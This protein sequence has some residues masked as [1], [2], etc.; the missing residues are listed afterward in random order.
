MLNNLCTFHTLYNVL[1]HSFRLCGTSDIY[2]S[3]YSHLTSK[4][5]T[6][7]SP[8]HSNPSITTTHIIPPLLN[9]CTEMSPMQTTGYNKYGNSTS[10]I[11]LTTWLMSYMQMILTE[12]SYNLAKII[13]ISLFLSIFWSDLIDYIKLCKSIKLYLC[14][15]QTIIRKIPQNLAKF[16]T[17]HYFIFWSGIVS[18]LIIYKYSVSSSCTRKGRNYNLYVSKY[19]QTCSPCITKLA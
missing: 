3:L 5:I 14:C 13:N 11:I 16:W 19:F 9:Q 18:K 12:K 10:D 17:I 4:P 8:I 6:N 15:L 7:Q 2:P 1:D